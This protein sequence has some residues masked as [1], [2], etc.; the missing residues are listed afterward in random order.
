ML[1]IISVL[2]SALATLVA[3]IAFV[4]GVT[5]SA[6]LRRREQ[7]FRESL[8][9]ISA[10]D[11]RRRVLQELHRAA[12]AELIS[13]QLTPAWRVLWPWIAWLVLAGL[14]TQTGYNVS[15]Y[16]ASGDAWGYFD[17]S[18]RVLGDPM[19]MAALPILILGSALVFT[20]YIV[21]LEG[22]AKTAREFFTEAHVSTPKTF[23]QLSAEAELARLDRGTR[24]K[25]E[26]HGQAFRRKGRREGALSWVLTLMPGLFA[27][28]VGMFSWLNI[29]MA[30]EPGDRVKTLDSLDAFP[31]VLVLAFT[32]TGMG[33]LRVWAMTSRDLKELS[34]PSDYPHAPANRVTPDA[35]PTI[36]EVPSPTSL[37]G[38][39][40][41]REG[42]HVS[43]TQ[44]SLLGK[45]RRPWR[46]QSRRDH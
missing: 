17:F 22:R 27:A 9:A 13:R 2:A 43:A 37:D 44:H 36:H 6:R 23:T 28:C 18:Q 45:R 31:G 20:S 26:G 35:A 15:D 7:F 19:G 32:L 29:W 12:I 30:R 39:R 5:R 40:D 16:L 46:F 4:F 14:F 24:S 8:T 3:T 21:T 10:D 1:G 41:E 38:L 34:L 42:E 33:V 25:D 11:P